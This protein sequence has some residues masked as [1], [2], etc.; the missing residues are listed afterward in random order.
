[1]INIS[2]LDTA[3]DPK[4]IA[5]VLDTTTPVES[6][7]KDLIFKDQG[8]HPFTYISKQEINKVISAL[9]MVIGGASAEPVGSATGNIEKISP[10]VIAGVMTFTATEVSEIM[11]LTGES[12]AQWKAGVIKDAKMMVAE[13]VESMCAKSLTGTLSWKA[14]TGT[15]DWDDITLYSETVPNT[16]ISNWGSSSVTL[17]T[18]QKN[19]NTMYDGMKDAGASG[20]E[21]EV[22]VW[23]DGWYGI[24]DKISAKT[25]KDVVSARYDS[26]N[27]IIKMGRFNLRNE[28]AVY[29]N[30]ET[31]ATTNA[32]ADNTCLM[33]NPKA[34]HKLR[35][36]K[37]D[38]FLNDFKAMPFLII[39]QVS[40]NGRVMTIEVST[41]PIP[42]FGALKSAKGTYTA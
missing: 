4:S 18:V 3:F 1:M 25:T 12:L 26:D 31:Q 6:P 38:N 40:P 7:I 27:E 30:A 29:K 16:A 15:N 24:L 13:T 36:L 8:T 23:S 10:E 22:L 21:I 41:K 19:L 32:V 39:P 33:I 2:G 42:L 11:Q 34:G 37:I 28:Q 5:Q 17:G 9:P 20:K 14:R 35:Y